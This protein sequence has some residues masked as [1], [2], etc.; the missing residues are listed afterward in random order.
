MISSSKALLQAASAAVARVPPSY[1]ADLTQSGQEINVSPYN[2]PGPYDMHVSHN[3]SYYYTVNSIAVVSWYTMSTAYDLE[4]ATLSGSLTLKATNGTSNLTSTAGIT[5]SSDGT[6]L[7]V[8][9]NG[10]AS[11][12]YYGSDAYIYEYTLSTAWD[13]TTIS[14][15][16]TNTLSLSTSSLWVARMSCL[17]ICNNDTVIYVTTAIV[18]PA[19]FVDDSYSYS[20]VQTVKVNMSTAKDLSTAT[21]SASSARPSNAFGFPRYGWAFYWKPDGTKFIYYQTNGIPGPRS[22]DVSTPWDFSTATY[23]TYGSASAAPSASSVKGMTMKPD[24]TALYTVDSV[25]DS[26]HYFTL[27]TAYDVS[28]LSY[29]GSYSIASQDTQPYDVQFKSDGT[30]M[31]VFGRTSSSVYE[32]DLS[33]AWD[34]TTATYNS[35]NALLSGFGTITNFKFKSDGTKLWLVNT[36]DVIET[37]SLSTAWDI[38]TL[39]DDNITYNMRTQSEFDGE[40]LAGTWNNLSIENNGQLL[41]ASNYRRAYKLPLSTAYDVSTASGVL[42]QDFFPME[43]WV[44]GDATFFLFMNTDGTYITL[45]RTYAP[46]SILS[47]GTAYDLSTV[48]TRTAIDTNQTGISYSGFNAWKRDGTKYFNAAVSPLKIYQVTPSAA[49]GGTPSTFI[50]SNWAA[51]NSSGSSVEWGLYYKNDGTKIYTV[52]YNLDNVFEYTLSTAYDVGTATLTT[53]KSITANSTQPYGIWFKPDGTEMYISDNGA[54]Q[55]HNYTLS[56]AWDV[57]TASYTSAFTVSGQSSNPRGVTFKPDGTR[58]YVT[59]Y[60]GVIYSYTLATAWDITTASYDSISFNPPDAGN[61]STTIF[62][63]DGTTLLIKDYLYRLWEYTCS[64]AWD[65]STATYTNVVKD[66]NNESGY[67]TYG[68]GY[69]KDGTKV[70]VTSNSKYVLVGYDV[71]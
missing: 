5:V 44:G 43:N 70:A 22:F 57:S 46:P 21:V 27:S 8:G 28:T 7:Y 63:S 66:F 42:E 34:S 38:T 26:V 58:M 51:N 52:D 59:D 53:T 41:F 6:K 68:I 40:G 30:K 29:Q 37:L 36:G 54:D 15:G 71:N 25:S 4:T 69:A 50:R 47:V 11:G 67:Y 62:N 19:Q 64:T 31:Y 56:T 24:G 60:G 9:Y 23:D 55:I 20:I 33:T 49:Y 48:S 18:D 32:Y 17:D 14:T 1:T 35:V 3:G 65:I 10:T 16:P 61:L 13:L 2:H 12:S 39:T 45:G